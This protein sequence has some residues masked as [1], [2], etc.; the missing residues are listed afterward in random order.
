MNLALFPKTAFSLGITAFAVAFGGQIAQAEETIAFHQAN[1][2]AEQEVDS[3]PQHSNLEV[4]QADITPGRATRSSPSYFGVAGN[5]GVRGDTTLSE[6]NPTIF[7]KVGL[8][9]NLSVRP[10]AVI[11]DN[12]VFLVPLTVDLPVG[13][14]L[15]VGGT[16]ENRPS[17]VPYLGGGLALSTARDST[18]GGLLSGG[19]DVPFASDFTANAGVNVGFIDRTDVGVLLGIGFNF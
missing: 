11:G 1:N 2:L 6:S 17:V 7:S 19:I 10:S 9:N 3:A 5:L 14:E 12:A 18:I 4:A 16:P 15:P 8:T 13:I